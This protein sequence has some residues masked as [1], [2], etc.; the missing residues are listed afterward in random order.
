MRCVVLEC[1]L[2]RHGDVQ[3]FS[4]TLCVSGGFVKVM[5]WFLGSS[6]SALPV[7]TARHL[8]LPS[9]SELSVQQHLYLHTT[10][11]GMSVG[12]LFQVV[13]RASRPFNPVGASELSS[14]GSPLS[15]LKPRCSSW[16]RC[17]PRPASSSRARP[18]YW[19]TPCLRR[20]AARAAAW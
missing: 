12:L 1:I 18:A 6:A 13:A 20:S 17:T 4:G 5:R 9:Y 3:S 14:L 7:Y 10:L 8:C 15:S 19:L 16:S 11:A 2:W